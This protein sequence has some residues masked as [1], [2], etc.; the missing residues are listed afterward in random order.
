MTTEKQDW[1]V[2]G[3]I[4]RGPDFSQEFKGWKVYAHPKP[5]IDVPVT[6]CAGH[7]ASDLDTEE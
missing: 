7:V 6:L 3:Y 2:E 4:H 5:G 1:V